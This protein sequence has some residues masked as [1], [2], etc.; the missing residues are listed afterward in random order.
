MSKRTPAEEVA[1]FKKRCEDL[2]KTEARC[3]LCKKV[4]RDLDPN[5]PQTPCFAHMRIRQT[6]A[7]SGMKTWR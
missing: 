3:P 4:R 1:V 2:F 5:A 6:M 7:L